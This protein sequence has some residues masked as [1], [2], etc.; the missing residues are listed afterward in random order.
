MKLLREALT[1]YFHQGCK[2]TDQF[3]IG[4]EFE[5][6]VVNSDFRL[7]PYCCTG[8][9]EETLQ[10]MSSCCSWERV[11]EG[12]RL[13]GLNRQGQAVT[14]EPSGAIEF[15]TSPSTSLVEINSQRNLFLKQLAEAAESFGHRILMVGVLPYDTLESVSLVPKRRYRFMYDYMP[16]VGTRGREMMKLSAAVQV[17]FD[18]SSEIDAMRKYRLAALSTPVFLALSANSGIQN[19]QYQNVASL[20]EDIWK[21][22]DHH[23]CG[24]PNFVFDP[25]ASF[26]SYA[27]WALDV[28]M[29]FGVRDASLYHQH[30][31]T[32]GEF[33]HGSAL[34]DD[35]MPSPVATAK[36][37]ETHLSTLFPWVRLKQYIEIRAFDM[38]CPNLQS[39][40]VALIKGLFYDEQALTELEALLGSFDQSLTTRLLQQAG[41]EGLDGEVDTIRIRSL[42]EKMVEIASGGL[43]RQ[44]PTEAAMLTPLT[45]RIEGWSIN[46]VAATIREI[47]VEQSIAQ[48][49]PQNA[50]LTEL[51]ETGECVGL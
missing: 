46:K 19:G 28:P 14:I 10:Y 50:A 22:T 42:A 1:E 15:S 34:P 27:Q 23:R 20:R 44:A 2:T 32:F 18:Y 49:L 7:I 21:N 6:F 35:K 43:S 31:P 33:L 13:V 5:F 39:A 25:Q 36:D 51:R 48:Y 40:L 3:S 30:H 37:W 4:A 45:D 17:S 41:Q 11:Y 8:G 9:V 24:I 29:Y 16:A 12:E 38:C 47:G 26:E